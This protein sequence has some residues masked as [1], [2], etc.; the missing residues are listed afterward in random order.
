MDCR[1]CDQMAR[2]IVQYLVIF[3]SKNVPNNKKLLK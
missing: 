1:Q 2:L 3:N